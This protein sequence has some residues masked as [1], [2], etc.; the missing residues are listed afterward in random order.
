M[1]G[2]KAWMAGMVVMGCVRGALAWTNLEGGDHG[3]SNWVIAGGTY[4]ASNHYNIGTV[5]I[6][7]GSVVYVQPWNNGKYGMVE[8]SATNITIRGT[9]DA[10]GAGYRGGNGG[11]GANG[12]AVYSLLPGYSGSTGANGGG[13]FGGNGGVGGAGGPVDNGY[14]QAGGSGGIGGYSVARGQGDASTNEAINMGS[15]GGGGGGGGSGS[16]Y[17]ESSS[18]AG[19]GGAGNYGGGAISLKALEA[20]TVRGVVAACGRSGVSG[21]GGN[22]TNGRPGLGGSGGGSLT[23]GQSK[24]GLGHPGV[25]NECMP[26]GNG[27]DGGAGA[28]GGI[29]LEAKHVDALGATVSNL[30]G[31]NNPTNGGTLKIFFVDHQ[32][33]TYSSGRLYLNQT[34]SPENGTVFEF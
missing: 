29:L 16:T 25:Y 10:S 15:G 28:G 30:G 9:L 3:G 24:G 23:G 19:G 33:G 8:I 31:G 1:N 6:E 26:S 12:G 5:T 7:T 20:L 4:I 27:G 11:G 22:G 13:P 14:G 21:N 2:R 18:G 34:A 17:R 32:A